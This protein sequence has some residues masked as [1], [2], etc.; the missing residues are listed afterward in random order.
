MKSKVK[1]NEQRLKAIQSTKT[2][3]LQRCVVAIGVY[4]RK[5]FVENI[6]MQAVSIDTGSFG[7]FCMVNDPDASEDTLYPKQ[8]VYKP[9]GFISQA[10]SPET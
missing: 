10:V 9:Q 1:A 3:Q 7:T 2:S 5:F 8:I 6:H 4:L